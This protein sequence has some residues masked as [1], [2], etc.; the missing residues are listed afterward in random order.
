M[1]YILFPCSG[2]KKI[3][4]LNVRVKISIFSLYRHIIYCSHALARVLKDGKI[5]CY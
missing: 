1:C 5:F 4:F 2:F 3:E